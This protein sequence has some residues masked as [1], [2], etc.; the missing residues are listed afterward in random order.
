MRGD[1]GQKPKVVEIITLSE[2]GGAQKVVWQI[3][4]GLKD[5]FNFIVV[6]QPGGELVDWLRRENIKVITTKH[7]KRNMNPVS[8]LYALVKLW[9]ILRQEQPDVVHCHSS[10]AGALGRLAAKMAGINKVFFTVHGWGFNDQQSFLVRKLYIIIE[11]LLARISNKIVCVSTNDK[12][13]GML[14]KI[15]EPDKLQVI[16]NGIDI[17]A[18]GHSQVSIRQELG[19][20]DEIFLIGTVGRVAEQKDPLAFIEV[21]EI[22]L[23]NRAAE[24]VRF[25]WIGDGP[26]MEE[27]LRAVAEKQLQDRVFF[28]G[29][30][31]EAPAMISEFHIFLLLSKWEGLPLVL[32]EALI[33]GKP[34]VAYDVGGVSELIDHKENG[35]LIKYEDREEVISALLRLVNSESLCFDMGEKSKEVARKFEMSRMLDSYAS[36]YAETELGRGS[37]WTT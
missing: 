22:L 13:V 36:L 25:V 29:T 32:L 14:E 15:A 28:C 16:H 31:E 27:C 20:A 17:K 33:N 8:D 34:L 4:S 3:V 19:I 24:R 12:E 5:E 1:P 26:L 35:F 30:K 7:L 37:V 21:A 11:R 9:G 10:K 18:I 6:C 2:I 23:R